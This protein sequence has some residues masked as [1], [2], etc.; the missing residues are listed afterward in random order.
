MSRFGQK[1]VAEVTACYFKSRPQRAWHACACS[2]R[3]LP[4][5][6]KVW[7]ACWKDEG[8]CGQAQ[9]GPA[10]PSQPACR[11]HVGKSAY[12]GSPR[13]EHPTKL[14]QLMELGPQKL[15]VYFTA[16][17]HPPPPPEEGSSTSHSNCSLHLQVEREMNSSFFW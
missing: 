2:L 12:P 1:T 16:G 10:N 9:S 11:P 8:A 4:P 17:M 14:S 7:L 5:P 15:V 3:T 6:E 13:P